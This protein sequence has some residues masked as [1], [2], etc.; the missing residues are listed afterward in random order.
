[1]PR[2]CP[3]HTKHEA[4]GILQLHADIS[5]THYATGVHERTR[6]RWRDE[7]RKMQNDFMSEKTF[8][9]DTKRTENQILAQHCAESSP[10]DPAYNIE[11]NDNPVSDFEDFAFIRAPLMKYARHL[12]ADLRPDEVDFNRITLTL[13]RIFDRIQQLDQILPEKPNS[14][15]VRLGKTTTKACSNSI[16]APGI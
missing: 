4:V 8:H 14:K 15:R 12:A 3:I 10:S 13:S 5:F 1:M 2:K 9:S 16:S 11:S 6:R 7:L